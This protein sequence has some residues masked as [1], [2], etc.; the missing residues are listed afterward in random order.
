MATS[1]PPEQGNTFDRA[2]QIDSTVIR[3][4]RAETSAGSST[5][6]ALPL[7]SSQSPWTIE[8][9]REL[10]RIATDKA[11]RNK[12]KINFAAVES[13]M[14]V[15]WSR[16]RGNEFSR[17]RSAIEKRIT[18]FRMIGEAGLDPILYS[19]KEFTPE[20]DEKLLALDTNVQRGS[21]KLGVN[22]AVAVTKFEHRPRFEL[23]ARR[24]QLLAQKVKKEK[25]G[26]LTATAKGKNDQEKSMKPKVPSTASL[27]FN[28]IASTSGTRPPQPQIGTPA[29]AAPQTFLASVAQLDHDLQPRSSQQQS[30]ISSPSTSFD[31]ISSSLPNPASIKSTLSRFYPPP[32]SQF[33]QHSQP[34]FSRF[35][36]ETLESM[37][38]FSEFFRSRQATPVQTPRSFSPVPQVHNHNQNSLDPGDTLIRGHPIDESSSSTAP[39]SKRSLDEPITPRKKTKVELLVDAEAAKE[40]I[41][42]FKSIKQKYEELDAEWEKT[43]NG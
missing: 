1:Q 27:P 2:T 29:Q 15:Y 24:A 38:T 39:T 37:T 36:P 10:L 40:G 7:V 5:S 8:E 21:G 26:S 16:T 12:N 32:S 17:T 34:T 20:E 25:E 14:K 4:S 31:Y 30:F 11:H 35:E 43:I 28:P 41:V 6:E 9:D 33:Y 18:R 42:L 13:L 23:R 22:W 19:F 3:F